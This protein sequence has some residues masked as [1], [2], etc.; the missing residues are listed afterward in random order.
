MFFFFISLE[1]ISSAVA[2]SL[3]TQQKKFMS[4]K[5]ENTNENYL[6]KGQQGSGSAEARG[7]SREAQKTDVDLTDDQKQDIAEQTDLKPEDIIS[8][9]D[10]GAV[11]GRDDLSGTSGDDMSGASTDQPTEKM[12]D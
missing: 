9:R 4:H 8:I 3:F 2:L 11:S 12:N 1:K 5:Q 10:T 7:E 6:Q